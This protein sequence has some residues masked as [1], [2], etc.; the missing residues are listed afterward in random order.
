MT[1]EHLILIPLDR[2]EVDETITLWNLIIT[3]LRLTSMVYGQGRT[4]DLNKG[5]I[6]LHQGD[7][8]ATGNFW[9]V[10]NLDLSGIEPNFT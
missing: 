9:N 1:K 5:L 2:Y 4:T 6:F 10:I 8:I 3:N 7:L